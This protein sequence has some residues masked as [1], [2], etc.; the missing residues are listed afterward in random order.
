MSVTI[1]IIVII[2]P[3]EFRREVFQHPRGAG[4]WGEGGDACG[5]KRDSFWLGFFY[6][7]AAK[8]SEMFADFKTS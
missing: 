2:L 4:V 3:E 6:Y 5:G 7:T 8:Q 1:F